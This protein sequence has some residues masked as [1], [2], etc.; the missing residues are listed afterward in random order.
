MVTPL[1]PAVDPPEAAGFRL[2]SRLGTGGFGTVY[3]GRRPGDRHGPDTLAAVKLLKREF[4]EDAQHMQRFHQESKALERCKGARIPELLALDFGAGRQPTLAT[5]FIPGL[6]LYRVL[7]AHGGA[8]PRDTVHTVAAE[9]VDTLNT[10]HHKGLLHRDLHPGNILLTQDGPWIIDFGLTRIRGQRVTLT[11]DTVIGHPHFCAPEQIR[12]LARTGSATDV[13]GI[14]GIVLH[15]LTGHPPYTGASDARAML[16]RRVSGGGPDLSRLPDDPLGRL[17]RSCLAEDPADRPRLDE[18]AEGLGRPGALRL[19][20][21]VVRLL[22]G[23]RA[24]LRDLLAGAGDAADL[25][26]PFRPG[27]RSWSADVGDW[28]QSVVAVEEGPV[29][30]A[31]GD[32]TVRW[33]DPGSGR[34]LDRRPGFTAP[35]RLRADGGVLLVCDAAG[36]LESW[37]AR[38][39]KPWWAAAAGSLTG[40]GVLLRGQSVFLG[41]DAG[42]LHHF[43][44]VTRRVWWHSAPVTDASGAPAVPVAAGARHVYL[45]AARGLELLAVDE[46]DGAVCWEKPARLPAPVLAP[47]LPLDDAV[48]VA[49]GDGGL[50]RLAA[51]DGSVLWEA[52]LGAPVAAAPVR[53]S[54]TV[55]VADTAGT[56]HCHAAATGERIWRAPYGTHEEFFALCADGT[57]VYAGGWSGRLQ[58]LD[59]RGGTSLQSFDLGGQILAVAAAPGGRAVLAASSGGTLHAL[60]AAAAPATVPPAAGA[61]ATTAP[62]AGPPSG[63]DSPERPGPGP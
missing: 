43:D 25:T 36:R 29:V 31:D 26:V 16:M 28:P 13:F 62:A 54:G 11:L 45:S 51:A 52:V 59:A 6:S 49:D 37:D 53:V 34:E 10:A 39:R 18:V 60:P 40:A 41:D 5:R 48:V 14:A 8:L 9:L 33:L 44:A 24:G 38:E 1:D 30:T 57:T 55:V 4:T 56:V 35:V 58:L 27:R 21:D 3:L 63:P 46:E 47:P 42:R 2:L 17:L 61:P 22:A 15:A 20:D 7:E 50:R 23:H 12:G 19:P 32:G